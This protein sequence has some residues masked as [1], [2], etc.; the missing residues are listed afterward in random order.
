MP[1]RTFTLVAVA[2]LA[3]LSL[4][5]AQATNSALHKV[6]RIHLAAMGSGAEA[7]RFRTLLGEELQRVGFE[8]SEEAKQ[9]D[10]VLSGE[11]SAEAHGNLSQARVTLLLKSPDGKRTI[12]SGDYISQHKGEGHEDVVKTLAETCAERLR[13]ELEKG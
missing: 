5:R 10:A 6:S 4:S 2:C 3:A 7:E 9:S 13:K 11:F 12:W 1:Y 8:V